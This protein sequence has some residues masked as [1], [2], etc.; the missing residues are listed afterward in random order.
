MR[1]ILLETFGEPDVMVVSEQPEPELPR[2][3]FV[4][5]IRAAGINFADVVERRGRYSKDQQLPFSLGKEAA[6]VVV[7]KGEQASG[8]ELGEPV[9][10]IRFAG[11]CYAE[12][13][14]VGP[15][16]ILRGPAG[17]DFE[18]LAAFPI[19]FATAWYGQNEIAR[20][21]SGESVLIQAA[22]GGVGSAAVVLARS[23]GA[24]PIIGTAGSEEKCR[25]VESLGA[26]CCVNYREADFRD[27]VRELTAGRGVDYVLESVGGDIFE[28]SL[29][30]LAPMGRA[31]IIGFSSISSGYADAVK[32]I[33][34]LTLFHRSI[35]CSGLNVQNLDFPTRS[36]VW[37]R[38][39]SHVEQHELKPLI[40]RT[41]PL[42]QAADAHAALEQ[43]QSRGKLLLIP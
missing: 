26:D 33:H 27:A 9:I 24:A 40:G 8:F 31:V 13:V 12:R 21:R 5:E 19:V 2:D 30:A 42:D 14:A 11:G 23:L 37:T 35:V 17:Y 18:Q 34:P 32:R 25:W 10:V 1:K 6:G 39:L 15:D 41:Y 43:R 16:Q 3:G 38:L 7:A 29:Q 36:H 4:V 20:V 28:H 22:A